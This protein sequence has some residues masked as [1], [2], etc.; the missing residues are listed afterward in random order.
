MMMTAQEAE[1][2][3]ERRGFQFGGQSGSERGARASAGQPRGHKWDAPIAFTIDV[4]VNSGKENPWP[5][6]ELARVALVEYIE[7]HFP[8]VVVEETPD[9]A[10]TE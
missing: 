9:D 4:C 5:P 7:A 2:R 3:L 8:E 6:V 10:D 1:T